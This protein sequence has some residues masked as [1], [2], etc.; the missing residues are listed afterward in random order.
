MEI[1]KFY[2]CE[3]LNARY[4]DREEVAYIVNQY[5]R[6]SN[7]K[8]DEAIIGEGHVLIAD[9]GKMFALHDG[10]KEIL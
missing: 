10:P 6:N 7:K 2:Y 3:K 5:N 1:R 9:D 4:W 8:Y